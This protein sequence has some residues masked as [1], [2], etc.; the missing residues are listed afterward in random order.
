M[1]SD[2]DLVGTEIL[3]DR[4]AV[5]KKIDQDLG[6]HVDYLKTLTDWGIQYLKRSIARHGASPPHAV[7][8]PTLYRQVLSFLDSVHIQLRQGAVHA[9]T[10]AL[11]SLWEATLSIEWIIENGKERWGRQFY[12]SELRQRRSWA[13][14]GVPGTPEYE[15][16]KDLG[17]GAFADMLDDE[18]EQ[19]WAEEQ[20]ENIDEH[21]TANPRLNE[22][23]KKFEELK[24]KKRGREPE[25]YEPNGPSSRA[26]MAARLGRDDE[27]NILYR[28]WSDVAHGSRSRH[29]W[30]IDS[31][32]RIVVEP[33]RTVAGLD[34][35]FSL[36]KTFGERATRMLTQEFT[37][38]EWKRLSDKLTDAWADEREM[39][40]IEIEETIRETP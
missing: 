38:A 11:R 24:E 22:L 28:H 19:A 36:T 27:Y 2:I 40:D 32:S 7:L 39:P 26:D 12:V 13:A 10:P 33:I 16:T 8:F 34:H 18:E 25:W 9:A 23:N 29:H 5:P 4:K 1:S 21:L 35:V 20:V 3:L 14:M 15:Q 31:G 30:R 37:P 17:G 6:T